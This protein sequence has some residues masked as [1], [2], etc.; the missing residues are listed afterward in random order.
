MFPISQTMEKTLLILAAG[1][2]SR[3]GGLKQMEGFGPSGETILEYSLFDAYRAG[4]RKFVFVIRKAIELDFKSGILSRLPD[5]LKWELCFQELDALPSGFTVPGDRQ[6]PWGTGHAV[7]VARNSIEGPFAIVNGD[8]FYGRDG[9]VQLANFFDL[10]DSTNHAMVA[11]PLGRTLSTAGSVSRGICV[12]DVSHRLLEMREVH[13]IRKQ[14]GS[15]VCDSECP[16]ELHDTTPASMN[17][18]GFQRSIFES[19][20]QDFL[21]FLRH[22]GKELKSEFYIPSV[23]NGLLQEG[24]TAFKVFQSADDWMGVTNPEDRAQVEK[25]IQQ[26]VESGVYPSRLWVVVRRKPCGDFLQISPATRAD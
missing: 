8:D 5:Y 7:W 10:S 9:F 16:V 1:L 14:Q 12:T 6:K 20:E 24:S 17:L 15:I 4:F 11:Y 25:G 26:L 22:S 3:Y 2:G 13:G 19:V 23:V 18:F 21:A